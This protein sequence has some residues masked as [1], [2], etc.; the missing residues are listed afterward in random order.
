MRGNL[1]MFGV[2]GPRMDLESSLVAGSATSKVNEPQFHHGKFVHIK[3]H[4]KRVSRLASSFLL[5]SFFSSSSLSF[6]FF[7]KRSSLLELTKE[8]LTMGSACGCRG[9]TR[10]WLGARA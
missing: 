1:A 4:G 9:G 8:D 3:A 6:S 5:F 2:N 10:P 7:L